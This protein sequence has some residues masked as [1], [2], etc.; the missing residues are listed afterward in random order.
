MRQRRC[1]GISGHCHR[2]G[3]VWHRGELDTITWTESGHLVRLADVGYLRGGC[4][5]W[6][7]GFSV[8]YYTDDWFQVVPVPIIDRRFIF[9]GKLYICKED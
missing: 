2:M 1:N 4:A 9:E 7:Q 6:Q 5:N 8:V 3:V